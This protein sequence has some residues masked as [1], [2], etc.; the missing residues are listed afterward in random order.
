M[1][2]SCSMCKELW[3]IILEVSPLYGSSTTMLDGNS[4]I[5]QTC[6]EEDWV[7]QV[8]VIDKGYFL[9]TWEGAEM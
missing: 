2:E 4:R 5:C 8:R 7:Y 3:I 9:E 6:G 1:T